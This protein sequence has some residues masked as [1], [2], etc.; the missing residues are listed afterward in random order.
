MPPALALGRALSRGRGLQTR[1]KPASTCLFCSLARPF[2]R[3]AARTT[4][5]TTGPLRLQERTS[6]APWIPRLSG[7]CYQSTESLSSDPRADLRRALL[8][9]QTHAPNHVNLP[10]LQLA[11][12]NLS[13]PPGRE[14][15]R[16][17]VLSVSSDGAGGSSGTNTTTSTAKRLLRLALADPLR[18]AAAWE[19]RLE[20]RDAAG[21]GA[22]SSPLIVRVVGA[23]KAGR[24]ATAG[25]AGEGEEGRE[26]EEG[27]R[28]VVKEH[29]IPELRVSTPLL[30]DAELEMLVADAGDALAAA[31]AASSGAAVDDPVLVPTVDVAATTAGHVAPIGTPVH[32]ALLVGDG[33][34]GAASILAL[35]VLEGR[36]VVMG[37]VNFK[38]LGSEDAAG[39]PLV[40]VN[41]DAA[42]E[43]LELF[44]SDVSNAMKYEALWTEANIG[45]ISEWLRKSALP[46][47]EGVTKAPVR[48]LVRSL[49]R[50]ARAAVQGEEA[51]DLAA[52]LRTKVQ[53]ESVAHL[54]RAL[55]DWAQSAHQELQQQ[56]DTAFTTGPWSKL[57]WWKLVWRADDVGMVTSEMVAQRFL[58]RAEQ[59]LIFLAGRIQEA[60]VVE[61]QQ[62]APLYPGPALP[63]PS[64]AEHTGQD[65][66]APGVVS[67]WPSHI[68]FT[69]HY[70]QTKT[71]P[72]LQALAQKLVVQ[73]AS[74]AG[75]STALT[76]LSYLSG[77]GAYEC[78]AI[79]A[80]GIVLSCRRLQQK[81]DAAREYWEGEVREEGRKAIRATEASVAEVLDK[82]G[83]TP[84]PAANRGA[85]LKELRKAEEIITR[86]EEALARMK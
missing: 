29:V 56:L 74:L 71:V 62:G 50:S 21:D 35:P 8:D 48:N 6:L 49:L 15:V 84:D 4:A 66:V 57:G 43:G 36:D 80:L 16:V 61:G 52:E 23:D 76:G 27:L 5:R 22:G 64:T 20:R 30:R 3:S 86:A 28:T 59:G 44:R 41:V 12:R 68:P 70:L 53:P 83:R 54:D 77:F 11:L 7:R 58:P 42:S 25:A 19:A 1:P 81:W 75:L 13:E 51:R 2:P 14:S 18:P 72:A 10:R 40:A 65:S 46:D 26:E 33:V 34:R 78:G 67:K 39:C 9:L 63:G 55:A 47:G 45:P 24:D 85:Q 38:G 17:A 73:S 82:A 79:A 37:V 32:L 31:A 60:G 69:R